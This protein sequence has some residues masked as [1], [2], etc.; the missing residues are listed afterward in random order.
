M[1]SRTSEEFGGSHRRNR[2]EN[3][4]GTQ[5]C[6]REVVAVTEELKGYD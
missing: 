3:I 1:F 4:E 6:T 2:Q 5:A